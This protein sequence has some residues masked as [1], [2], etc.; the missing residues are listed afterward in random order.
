MDAV[1][2]SLFDK[3]PEPTGIVS[4][5]GVV[6]EVNEAWHHVLGWSRDET[7][8]QMTL[9][10]GLWIDAEQRTR[11]LAELDRT[12]VFS[13]E[14][15][16]RRR[17]GSR[18]VV[19]LTLRRV[20]VAGDDV[21]WFRMRDLTEQQRQH[22]QLLLSE[23][24]HRAFSEATFEGLAMS[25]HGKIV[26]CNEQL[27]RLFGYPRDEL[28]GFPIAQLSAPVTRD[29]VASA[30]TDGHEGPYEHIGKRKDGS[31]FIAAVRARMVELGDRRIRFS[32]VRDLTDQKRIEHQLEHLVGEL[33]ARNAEM[34][35]FV[36]TVSHDL[37]S[38][39]VTIKG[40]VGAIET[41]V[42]MERFASIGKDLGRIK[43]AAD[44]MA[45]LLDDLLELSRVGRVGATPSRVDL[46]AVV[47]AAAELVA[48]RL[49]AR[50]VE[51]VIASQLPV[52]EGDR[53][54][55][56]QVFQNLLEN[57]IKYMGDQA[58]P[59]IE[60]GQRVAPG[61]AIVFVHDNGK[62]LA[63]EHGE[64][65]FGLFEK[66]DPKSEGTGVGLAL[67]RRIIEFHGGKVWVESEGLGKGSTFVVDIPLERERAP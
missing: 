59:R 4:D 50:P 52:V 14:I 48:G 25:E 26:D 6:L 55:M 23:A 42:A 21:V 40:F 67:V 20:L 18:I 43:G 28:F 13:E 11:T 66:L 56:I 57:A 9:A 64:R 3:L 8:G 36:R 10:L 31:T 15:E 5:S 24:R 39:V 46:G 47:H 16:L 54:R 12:G 44:R 2:R 30:V 22:Q 35:Q 51:L 45:E 38:P 41:D 27:A 32:S 60:V 29:L 17:D 61:R 53:G 19:E 7:I 1:F 49:A 62:G 37:K 63:R 65:V 33:R 34:E 58:L